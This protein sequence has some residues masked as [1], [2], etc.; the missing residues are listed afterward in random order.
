MEQ[1]Q[2]N[3]KEITKQA[4][5]RKCW[6]TIGIGLVINAAAYT[7]ISFNYPAAPLT[8]IGILGLGC[9]VTGFGVGLAYA[10]VWKITGYE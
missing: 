1:T 9:I 5:V 10:R 8:F 4:Y 3:R 7:Y 2:T 6:V